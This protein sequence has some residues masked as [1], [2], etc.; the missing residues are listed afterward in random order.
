[1]A[2]LILTQD[3][4]S[5]NLHSKRLE[6]VKRPRLG[7]DEKTERMTVP[8]YDLDRVIVCGSPCVSLPT[9]K[10]LMQEN[11]PVFFVSSHG[12][13][14]G[15]MTPDDNKNAARR[16]RQYE[17]ALKPEFALEV[18]RKIVFAKMRNSRRVLQRLAANREI[19]YQLAHRNAMDKLDSLAKSALEAE[20]MDELRGLEGMAAAVYFERLG[21]YFPENIPFKCRT[22]RPPKDSANALL[23][24][25]YTIVLGE[26]DSAVRSRGLDSCIGFLHSIE[27]G[28]PSMSL[29]LLEPFRAPCCDMTV[30]NI[31]NHKHLAEDDFEYHADDG[32]TYLKTEAKRKFFETYERAMTRKFTPVDGGPHVDFRDVMHKQISAL[33]KAMEGDD[34]F[35][36]F[37]MP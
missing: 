4:I 33:L 32:G 31:L 13:W 34:D 25:T 2:S 26:I 37:L 36:F 10:R 1:M 24:W 29:D 15:S 14:I 6:V 18:A 11:I 5:V 3:L 12:R 16:I 28:R 20:G 27:H 17:L 8:L 19:S 30:L 7:T 9:L 35:E 21:R 23:S 22:R